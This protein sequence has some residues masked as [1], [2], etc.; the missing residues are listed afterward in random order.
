[1]V[2][3]GLQG[4]VSAYVIKQ[5]VDTLADVPLAEAHS[6]VWWPALLFVGN[7]FIGDM[8][9]RVSSL[10]SYFLQPAVK[11]KVISDGFAYVHHHAY[12]Y[13]QD[14]L[15]GSIAANIRRL[16]ENIESIMHEHML[17]VIRGAVMLVAALTSMYMVHPTF[18]VAFLLWV[19]IFMPVSFYCSNVSKSLADRYAEA[20]AVVAGQVVDS[21]ANAHNV[22]IFSGMKAE[23]HYLQQGLALLT[24]RFKIKEAYVIKLNFF[25]GISVTS[26]YAAMLYYLVHLYGQGEV[27]IGD[28]AMILG[29]L[30]YTVDYVWWC[31]EHV[32][33]ILMKIGG[34]N[35]SLRALFIPHDIVDRPDATPLRVAHGEITFEQV[36]FRYKAET[37]LFE[38]KT[39]TIPP[40]QKV[41]LVGYS[42]GGKSSFINLILRLYNVS[43]GRILIDGQD[44]S[45]VTEES[46]YQ[47]IALIP[48]DPS[49]FHRS[50]MDNIR[51]GR[52]DASDDEVI[53]AAKQAQ[54]HDFICRNRDGYHALVGERGV[55]LSGGQR[56]RIA[57][58]RAILKNAPILILDEATSQLDSVTENDIQEALWLLMQGKTTIVIAHRLSTLL[59]MDRILVFDHGHIVESGSHAELLAKGGMYKT[60]WDAQVGGF[61]PEAMTPAIE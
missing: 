17:H 59:K 24:K 25:Q 2:I 36:Q 35:Q 42:G 15:S 44:I 18:F 46:L 54:A 14:R 23:Q 31:T 49:L 20:D 29:L 58:A 11:S 56:Q 41:G 34:C 27:T 19:V 37:P 9:W 57:I 43:A 61:L 10:I 52:I 26:L 48:Q 45:Q 5:I 47:A 32:E 55:K 1:M 12:Q 13:F 22:R 6:V 16:A 28:F 33:N 50:L 53:A 21:I 39:L 40:G 3:C 7:H 4:S 38:N 60:L 30:Y 51:Y 8:C